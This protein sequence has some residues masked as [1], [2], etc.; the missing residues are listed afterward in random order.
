[1]VQEFDATHCLSKL[2]FAWVNFVD[3][4]GF[5][6][7]VALGRCFFFFLSFQ[8]SV[9]CFFL[10]YFSPSLC[11]AFSWD[12]SSFFGLGEVE[13]KLVFEVNH[14]KAELASKHVELEGER[15]EH[16]I[17]KEALCAQVVESEQ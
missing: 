11:K 6:R 3:G 8:F 5:I 1:V 9:S 12:Q 14:L 2:S 16:Q 17:S 4:R 15:H 13:K 10:P 7:R